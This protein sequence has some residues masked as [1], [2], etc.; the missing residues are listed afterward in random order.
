MVKDQETV[1]RNE[2]ESPAV[3]R[4]S[5]WFYDDVEDVPVRCF[6]HERLTWI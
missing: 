1:E 4:E 5:D 6:K 3:E 2:S